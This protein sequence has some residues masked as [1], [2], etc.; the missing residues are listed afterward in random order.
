MDERLILAT[1][2]SIARLTRRMLAAA[3][4]G[5]WDE[6]TTLEQEVSGLFAPLVAHDHEPPA[7]AEYRRRK[8]ELIRDILADDAQIRLLVEPRLKDLSALLGSTRQ[9]QRLA[10]AY[11]TDG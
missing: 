9:E 2:E 7:G 1:Y 6:V 11:E 3:Q 8:V 4:A 10:R 5:L